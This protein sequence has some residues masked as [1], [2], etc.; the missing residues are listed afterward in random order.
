MKTYSFKFK[1]GEDTL[2]IYQRRLIRWAVCTNKIVEDALNKSLKKY[3]IFQ[4]KKFLLK[5]KKW[6]LMI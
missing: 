6:K 1:H 4:A 5:N 3:N 2:T